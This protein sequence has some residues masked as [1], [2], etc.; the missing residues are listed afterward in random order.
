VSR[1]F[2]A[3]AIV[4]GALLASAP[5]VDGYL[6]LGTRLGGRLV[7]VRFN[8]FP[9]RYFVTNRDVPGVPATQLQ[10][11]VERGFATW[12]AVPNLGVSSQFVG[13][14]AINPVGGDNANVIGFS[15]RPD[16]DRVLGSTSFTVDTVTG[17]VLE[18]DI[19]LNSS[20]SWSVSAAGVPGSQDVE[21]IAL[22]EIGHLLGLGHSMLGETELISGGRRVLGA[23][24]VMFPIA[25]SAGGLNRVLRADDI[26]GMSDIYGN[27]A[28]RSSTGSISGR[29]TKNGAGVTGA[30]VIAFHPATGKLVATFTLD[31]DGTFV[32]AGLDPGPQIIRAEPLDDA[33]T[34]SFLD[35]SFRVDTDFKVAFYNRLV[36][37]PRGG[38]ARNV[39]L[40]VVPKS[41]VR[42]RLRLWLDRLFAALLLAPSRLSPPRWTS[43]RGRA[44]LSLRASCSRW[45]R[46][47]LRRSPSTSARRRRIAGRL[48][49]VPAACGLGD[50]TREALRRR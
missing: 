35:A 10:Q 1:Q 37:V 49:L 7:D 36:T 50:T 18:S 11:A 47:R 31:A 9:I 5:A 44:A 23:E 17:E 33:E 41:P 30:H 20:F 28:F 24:S 12:A 21:S 27:Q 26:A 15:N 13:L 48:R 25:F 34:S 22:H 42:L 43:R 2:L 29:V 14:T 16:L 19:F 6:K 4:L 45:C 40:K 8:T 3:S 39:D 32:I 38:T 46:S